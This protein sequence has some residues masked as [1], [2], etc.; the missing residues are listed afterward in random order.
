MTEAL[1]SPSWYRVARLKPRLRGHTRVYRHQYRGELWY[2]LQDHAK[3]RYYRFSPDTYEVVGRMDGKLTVQELWERSS[4]Q[5]GDEGLTQDEV[6]RL[7]GQLHASDVLVCDVP[8]DTEELLRRA[9]TTARRERLMKL[10]SPLAIK[11]PLLDPERFLGWSM[12]L[13]RPLFS[14][15]GALLWLAVVGTAV[16]LAGLHW[17]ELTRNIVDRVLSA[18]NLLVM[19]LAYPL[20]KAFHELGHG[21]AVKVWG[22]EVHEMGIMFLVFF[23]VPYVD[24]SAASEFRAKHRRIV[25]GAAGILVELFLGALALL[26]WLELEPGPARALAYN[27]ILIGSVSTVLFN[28]NPLLRYDGYYILSDL[29]EIPNLARRGTGYLGWLI[30]RHGFGTDEPRPQTSRGEPF[31]FVAYTIAAFFYRAFI[32]TSI[33]LFLAGKF[34]FVGIL[35]ATWAVFSMVVLPV[36]KGTK[37]V[38]ASPK[39]RSKRPR[40]IAV[41][42]VAV[43]F[44]ALLLFTLPF[45]WRTR[46][47]GVVWPPEESLVRA[48]TNGFVSRV[49]APPNSRV[50]AGQLLIECRDP[51][52]A[53]NVRVLGA[54]LEELRSRYDAAHATDLVQAQIVAKE[55]D[56][57]R[58][59][60]ERETERLSELEIVSPVA[61]RFVVPRAKD[62]PDRWVTQGELIAFVLDVSRPTVRVVVPQSNVDLVR[63]RTRRVEVRMVE[64]LD[65]VIPARIMREVPEAEEQLPSAILG[66]PGGGE[67]AIDPTEQSGQKAF[68]KLFQF[69]IELD[70]PVDQVFV[71]GRVYV[72]F[73]HGHESLG[74]QWYR[75]LRQLFMRRF[76]V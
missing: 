9:Q 7:L 56:D 12:G 69:D 14:V 34:F 5:L 10:R 44:V 41:T 75:S 3:G 53:A 17:S 1:F 68:E 24:A 20:V 8:P 23:P 4:E 72:R 51:M 11:L 48:K 76:N 29:L 73:D 66:S 31:W 74:L 26:L 15:F 25:V 55:R 47:E 22:G 33:V 62:L 32:Y 35:L 21:Y 30:R 71:G 70:E 43:A 28:G 59:E 40:A 63:Q 54:R 38:M 58:A 2:V 67:I 13:V 37:F 64:R 46:I 6:V 50:E 57:V 49:V 52:L 65:R 45:P 60:L 42:A 18:E 39:L 16:V 61:G 36:V 19:G 27:V